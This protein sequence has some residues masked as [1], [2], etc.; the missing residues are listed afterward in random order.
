MSHKITICRINLSKWFHVCRYYSI[1]NMYENMKSN[2]FLIQIIYV[3]S[4]TLCF[5]DWIELV[6]F[7]TSNITPGP[8]LCDLVALDLSSRLTHHQNHR[9]EFV[10]Q[11]CDNWAVAVNNCQQ[12]YGHCLTRFHE[13]NLIFDRPYFFYWWLA[14][15]I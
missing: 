10:H 5:N 9:C 2:L 8:H 14:Q 12:S 1:L 11:T 7:H 6:H 4:P 13:T 15:F 3:H